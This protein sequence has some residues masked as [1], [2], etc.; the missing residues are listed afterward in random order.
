[1]QEDIRLWEHTPVDTLNEK[2]RRT[3]FDGVYWFNR[4]KVKYIL[5]HKTWKIQFYTIKFYIVR[6]AAGRQAQ[7]WSVHAVLAH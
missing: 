3:T 7:E 5:D 2:E 4:T 1:M 6:A